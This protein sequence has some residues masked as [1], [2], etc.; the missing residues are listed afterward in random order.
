M[1]TE[2]DEIA[3]R[4]AIKLLKQREGCCLRAYPDPASEL[5]KELSKH[6]LLNAFMQGKA[7]IPDYMVEKFDGSPWT[8]GYGETEGVKRGDVWTQEKADSR[9]ERRVREFMTGVIKAC[10]QLSKESPAKTAACT[11]LAYNIGLANFA[12]SSVCKDTKAKNYD[13]A[14][15]DFLLWNKV[16]SGGQLVV[17]AGLTTR[18]KIER[19]LY[20]SVSGV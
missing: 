17:S 3:V 12:S 2:L 9:L 10:P 13:K 15:D 8:I 6:N 5:S 11:S 1:D 20:L 19:D 16:R 14:A 7:E 4:V 18:R